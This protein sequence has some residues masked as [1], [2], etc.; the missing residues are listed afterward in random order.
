MIRFR[1]SKSCQ[2]HADDSRQVMLV[3]NM[4]RK[5]GFVKYIENMTCVASQRGRISQSASWYKAGG[6]NVS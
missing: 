6:A 3:E 1:D 2:G 4:T 5:R